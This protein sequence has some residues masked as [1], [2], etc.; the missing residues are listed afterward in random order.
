MRY[1]QAQNQVQGIAALFQVGIQQGALRPDLDPAIAARGFLAFQNGI[2][3]LWLT[4]P[5]AF[6]IQQTADQFA[7]LFLRGIV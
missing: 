5:Q 4:N 6:S 7:D 2:I 1:E 3:M